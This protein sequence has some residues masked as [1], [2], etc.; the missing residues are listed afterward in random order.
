M[1]FFM[2]MIPPTSTHQQQGHTVDRH[3]VHHFYKRRNGEAEALLT[4]HL[5]KHIPEQPYTCP[6][7]VVVKWCF[8]LK[9]KHRD[10][11]PY[12]N[13]PDVDNLCKSLYDIMGRL[14]YWKDDKQI[15]CGVTEKYWAESPG[16][17][18]RIEGIS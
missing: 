18:V 3:G 16:I 17:Y 8:P 15:V 1:E 2:N 9:A 6:L 13:K 12:T 4:A 11:E 7:K 5:I 10:G 14:G